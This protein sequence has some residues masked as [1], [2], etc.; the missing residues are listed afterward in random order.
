MRRDL[1]T[2]YSYL[3]LGFFTYLL[4]IQGNILPFL[5]QELDLS[6]RVVSLHS[7]AIAA[8]MIAVGLFG[9]RV[10]RRWGRRFALA[11]GAA[12]AA[13]GA[14][15]LCLRRSACASIA[16]CALIGALGALIPA[17]V[18]AL[19]ADLHGPRRN[20]AITEA[21]AASY[22][23]AMT[24]PLLTGLSIA[25]FAGWRPAVLTG[26]L[27]GILIAG[28]VPARRDR[29]CRPQRTRPPAGACLPPTGRTGACWS[30]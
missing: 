4:T 5:K 2:W 17:V 30:R 9:D 27:F 29:R 28:R 1:A 14:I 21:S 8:G 23:F 16:S 25:L 18:P 12:G 10:V 13:A 15:L 3:A 6:Y 22:A 11:L 20:V 7:G 24:A 19:L 26:A